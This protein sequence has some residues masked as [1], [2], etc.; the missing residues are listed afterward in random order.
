MTLKQ[1]NKVDTG[2]SKV[3]NRNNRIKRNEQNKIIKNAQNNTYR[4]TIKSSAE[5]ESSHV[6]YTGCH[7]ASLEFIR[8][9]T[10]C[11]EAGLEFI[12]KYI[13]CHEAKFEMWLWRRIDNQIK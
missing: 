9:Y 1:A 11:H 8:K 2:N 3:K 12:R 13:G 10:G 4:E 5:K 6:K 7:E